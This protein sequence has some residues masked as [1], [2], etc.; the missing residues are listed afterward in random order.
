MDS[1]TPQARLVRLRTFRTLRRQPSWFSSSKNEWTLA[2]ISFSQSERWW[3]EAMIHES[4][5]GQQNRWQRKRKVIW[6]QKWK[7]KKI[8]LVSYFL[9]KNKE[10]FEARAKCSKFCTMHNFFGDFGSKIW[11]NSWAHHAVNR[12]AR[13]TFITARVY[14]FRTDCSLEKSMFWHSHLP[15][16]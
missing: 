5:N 14:F 9:A 11:Q 8:L 15:H 4:T 16:L 3:R 6:K 12:G 2:T 1:L 10:L 7:P 13:T